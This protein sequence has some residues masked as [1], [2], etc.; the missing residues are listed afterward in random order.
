MILYPIGY[1]AQLVTIEELIRRE[2]AGM[3]PETA[4]RWITFFVAHNGQLGIGD[5]WRP[6]PS[7]TSAASMRGESFHQTQTYSDGTRWFTALDCVRRNPVAG[8]K[9]LAPKTGQIPVQGT[10][11]A[12]KWGIHA[13][14]GTP[15]S[16]GWES[17]HGQDVETD[18]WATWVFQGRKRPRRGYPIPSDVLP[19]VQPLPT[20]TSEV[21]VLNVFEALMSP[22]R[23]F[24]TR[25][26]GGIVAAGQYSV[27]APNSAGKKG[28]TVGVKII[29]AVQAGYCTVWPGTVP[30]PD[31][32]Q[33][34]FVPGVVSNTVV[35]VPLAADG[36]FKVYISQNAGIIIDLYG[37]WT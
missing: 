35:T 7:N 8:G 26:F 14:V 9:H 30:T 20:P 19:P 5:G 6:T 4:R 22:T 24:N 23:F 16:T 15:G 18:G 12:A 32:S 29:D 2:M 1:D 11:A 3:E 34:D 27:I 33:I 37:H 28:V 13:N 36:S 10:S 17:W 21:Q 31:V 25:G